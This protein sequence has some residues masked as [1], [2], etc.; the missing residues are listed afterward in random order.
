MF[1]IKDRGNLEK[2][3]FTFSDLFSH[4][5][6]WFTNFNTNAVGIWNFN[7]KTL[8]IPNKLLSR[9]LSNIFNQLNFAK[10]KKMAIFEN[11]PKT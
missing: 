6:I 1:L 10:E 11:F 9:V 2:F 5:Q 8:V 7:I 4:F 3:I